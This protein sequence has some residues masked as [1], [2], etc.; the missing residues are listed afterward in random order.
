LGRGRKK[1]KKK[2]KVSHRKAKGRQR[3]WHGTNW[4]MAG[5][6]RCEK[7]ERGLHKSDE[8]R[9]NDTHPILGNVGGLKNGQQEARCNIP[10][11][12]A[13]T[14]VL[15]TLLKASGVETSGTIS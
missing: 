15:A 9:P 4:H 11:R 2:N 6:H 13:H 3:G 8:T 14:R 7:E 10:T 1:K 5:E 12:G